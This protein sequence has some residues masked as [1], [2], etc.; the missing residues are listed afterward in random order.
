[1]PLV[2]VIIVNFN[3]KRLLE[4]CLSSV[5]KSD[6]P[7]LE[8][9][10]VD[11]ASTD[12]SIE[13]AKAKYPNQNLKITQNQRNLGFAM[14]NN[15]G[16][17]HSKG[18]Y[19]VFLNNDT[20]VEE[21][22]L[23]ELIDVMKTDRNIGAAQCKLL[24]MHERRKFDNAGGY[25]DRFISPIVRGIEEYDYGQY[26]E[27]TEIFWA[28]GAAFAVKRKVLNEVGLFDEDYF[29]EYE[30]TD[31]CWRI[32]LKGYKILF[33]PKSIVF[34]AGGAS[35]SRKKL[36]TYYC[37]HRNH[38]TTL[39]KNYD[40]MNVAKYL[41]PLLFIKIATDMRSIRTEHL[42]RLRAILFNVRNLRK[43]WQKRQKVQIDIRSISDD[44]LFQR[45]IF[46]SF[47]MLQENLLQQKR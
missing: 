8:V 45:N 20:E 10:L 33:V 9:I 37:F 29:L 15:V 11:N 23:K 36:E 16:I 46:L 47:N 7:N 17:K 28:K 39:L 4:N 40:L 3:N 12:G 31:L 2:S 25:V 26:D 19:L 35:I 27:I 44:A 5:F 18:E 41:P 32:W 42:I 34:H 43:I 38:I 30:E 14:G 6:Y 24:L 13:F 22:W 21:K 1:M